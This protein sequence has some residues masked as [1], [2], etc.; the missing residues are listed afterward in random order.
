M[1]A[2]G[3]HIVRIG[4]GQGCDLVLSHA[5]ISRQHAEMTF[6]DDGSIELK[7]LNSTG[8]TFIR[9]RGQERSII[10][11]RLEMGDMLRLGDYEIS[12]EDLLQRAGRAPTPA[13]RSAPTPVTSV[14]EESGPPQTRM[15]RCDCGT[16]KKRGEK[17]PACGS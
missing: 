1:S 16:I 2:E 11:T 9:R 13:V 17:C 14:N 5:S 15:V 6:G 7:D 4:R 3:G 8:G 12:L 10:E